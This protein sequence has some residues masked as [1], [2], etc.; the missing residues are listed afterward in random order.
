MVRSK[1]RAY[2]E[3]TRIVSPVK[4]VLGLARAGKVQPCFL[5]TG[6]VREGHVVIGDIFEELD[7][8]LAQHSRSRN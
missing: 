1:Q 6:T 3:H 5:V 2:G 4:V 8:V 7:L